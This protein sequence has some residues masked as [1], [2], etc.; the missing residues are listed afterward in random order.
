MK[1]EKEPLI[2]FGKGNLKRWGN[3]RSLIFDKGKAGKKEKFVAQKGFFQSKSYDIFYIRI[4]ILTGET[5]LY[6]L[7][8]WN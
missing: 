7:F 1:D 2:G 4:V 5:C 3:D 6:S 8:D